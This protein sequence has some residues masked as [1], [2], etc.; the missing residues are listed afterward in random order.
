MLIVVI[1]DGNNVEC[2]LSDLLNIYGFDFAVLRH[3]VALLLH[4]DF[5]SSLMKFANS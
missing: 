2:A 3:I 1:I 4:P 5:F